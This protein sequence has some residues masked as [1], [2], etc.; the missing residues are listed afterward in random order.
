MGR[1]VIG[2]AVDPIEEEDGIWVTVWL[3]R[4]ERRLALVKALAERGAAL[5]G[6]SES[7]AGRTSVDKATGEILLWPYW[8]QTLS[9]SPV[10]THS[11]LR[12]LKAALDEAVGVLYPATTPA[13]W[14]DMTAEV[15]DLAA[16]LRRT[17]H[18][19]NG[20]AKSG[21]VL[22]A[23]NERAIMEALEG[24]DS[25]TVAALSR[26]RDV[27]ARAHPGDAGSEEGSLMGDSP[28]NI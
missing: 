20:A 7:I 16:D 25:A 8:R 12:P 11:V 24:L 18:G 10:N 15:R 19:G 13:F 4:G 22:S 3:N 28:G 14:R 6:S 9:T 1:S 23:A 5:F 17:S 21:R 27:L 26:L 2:K